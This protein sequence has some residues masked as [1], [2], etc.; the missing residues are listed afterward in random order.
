MRF[1][2]VISGLPSPRSSRPRLRRDRLIAKTAPPRRRAAK[3]GQIPTAQS[4][5]GFSFVFRRDSTAVGGW[6]RI[7]VGPLSIAWATAGRSK[8]SAISSDR[9]RPRRLTSALMGTLSGVSVWLACIEVCGAAV[10][11]TDAATPVRANLDQASVAR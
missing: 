5:V 6:I 7:G 9:W 2:P 3:R 4:C 11:A 1:L 10:R 8:D